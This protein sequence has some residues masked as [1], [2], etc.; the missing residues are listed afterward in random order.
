LNM[1]N[2]IRWT[3]YFIPALVVELICYA[4][5][6]L[7]ALFVR[8]EPRLDVVKRLNKQ[9]VLLDRDY[10]TTPFYLWQTHD[11][12]VDEWW[13]GMYNTDHWF[14]FAQNWTQRDYDNS[15]FVRYYCRVMW[16]WRN[17]A[18]GW[19]YSLFSR[20]K[21]TEAK[22]YERGNEDAGFWYKLSV[23]K[24]SF[25]LECHIPLG[26]RYLSVNI[27]WKPH[28]TTDRLLY[29]NRIIGFRRH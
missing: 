1:N 12:A 8:R 26:P 5:T 3:L 14:K 29:A 22:M 13:Y 2:T 11:N 19:H 7:V 28:K 20:P 23:F 25:Q 17:C 18:Y 16:L 9:S 10:L 6:P 4:T 27:G 21:E 15:A 24:S